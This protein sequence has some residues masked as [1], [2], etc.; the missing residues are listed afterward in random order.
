MDK[1]LLISFLFFTVPRHTVVPNAAA[2][3]RLV[4]DDF[5][6]T[7]EMLNGNVKL[8]SGP[9]HSVDENWFTNPSL[10]QT[11]IVGV[12]TDKFRTGFFLFDNNNIPKELIAEVEIGDGNGALAT[13]RQKQKFFSGFIRSSK[14]IGPKYFVSHKGFRLGSPRED[15]IKVYGKPDTISARGSTEILGWDFTGDSV[16]Q[17]KS[18]RPGKPIAKDSWGYQVTGFI[19]NGKIIALILHNDIP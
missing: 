4:V 9:L 16:G 5:P 1:L 19:Q 14:K 3:P 10:H 8:K 6:V 7:D 11:L 13:T 12:Y 15:L 17:P 18:S 2:A